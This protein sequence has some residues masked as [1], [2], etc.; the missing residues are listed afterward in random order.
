[1]QTVLFADDTD[2][3]R[4][5]SSAILQAHGYT[6]LEAADGYEALSLARNHRDP[7]HLLITDVV[8]PGLGGIGL[9]HA[10]K[11]LYPEA[12]V[13]F[14]SGYHEAELDAHASFLQKPF[15]PRTLLHR[16]R[17][18]LSDRSHALNL[19]SGNSERERTYTNR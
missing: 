12:S 4:K 16:V 8:M 1:M 14:I 5:L 19:R 9:F 18:L 15:T 6:V 3:I 7:I 11:G 10:F 13:L 2:D 17:E